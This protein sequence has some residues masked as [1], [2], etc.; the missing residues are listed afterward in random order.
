MYLHCAK[1]HH[2]SDMSEIGAEGL[3]QFTV[4]YDLNCRK[5]KDIVE[6][7]QNAHWKSMEDCFSD[8]CTFG[9]GYKRA[10]GYCRAEFDAWGASIINEVKS[11]KDTGLWFRCGGWHFQNTWTKHR[12]QL[13]I[14]FQSIYLHEKL[15]KNW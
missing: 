7:H 14:K 10:K 1:F 4:M 12:N 6:L 11:T 13:N 15:Q 5:L 3:N 8:I 2:T 9:A